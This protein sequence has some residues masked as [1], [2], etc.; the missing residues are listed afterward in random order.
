MTDISFHYTDPKM[1]ED[2]LRIVPFQN[3]DFVL[4]A[5]SGKNKVWFNKL[6]GGLIGFEC[7]IEN[8]NDFYSWEKK[9]DWVI[10]N[11]PFHESWKFTEKA[12]S[13]ARKGVAWL[14]N[15][16]ALNSHMTPNRLQLLA[17][18]DFF[19]SHVHIVQDKRWF[20]RY[21][22]II[23]SQKNPLTFSWSK[24]LYGKEAENK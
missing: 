7:E 18:K 6:D 5:G 10:G 9:V 17:N 8:G 4:D 13:I 14:I 12:I 1:V 22:F 23:L 2:L 16:Q 3:G 21:Y 20:G 15:N 19:V 11:P 24:K